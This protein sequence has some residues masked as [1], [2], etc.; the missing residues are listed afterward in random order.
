MLHV[1]LAKSAAVLALLTVAFSIREIRRRFPREVLFLAL[2]IGQLFV[3]S[4]LS[5]VWKGG[6]FQATLDFAKVLLVVL[7]IAVAVSTLQRLR[8]LIFT[9]AISLSAI[10]AV[11]IWKGRLIL[12]RRVGIARWE[13]RR[14]K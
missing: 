7:M 10:A 8:M 9:Q 4:L 5:P 13:L 6:A 3:A 2:L 11:T 1:P 12:G 14:P